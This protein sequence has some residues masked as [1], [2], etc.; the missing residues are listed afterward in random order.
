MRRHSMAS[1]GASRRVTTPTRPRRRARRSR[2]RARAR[3]GARDGANVA[4]DGDAR[5]MMPRRTFALSCASASAL[6]TRRGASASDTLRAQYA[7]AF[8]A[9][10]RNAATTTVPMTLERGGAYAVEWTLG[11]AARTLRGVVDTGSP[12]LT[13]QRRGCDASGAGA[14]WGCVE[15]EDVRFEAYDA[16]FETYGLQA[17]GRTSWYAGKRATL[18]SL[19]FE[20]LV[21]G[22]TDDVRGRDAA[23]FVG[24]VKYTN[25]ERGIRPS[26]LQQTD[27][28]SFALDFERETLTLSRDSLVDE[29]EIGVLR[30][31][32][33]RSIGAPVYH[34]ATPCDEL[35]INGERFETSKPIYVVFDSGTTGM[36]VDRQLYEDSDFHLGTYQTHMK[37][38]DTNGETKYCGSSLRTC[39]LSEDCLFVVTPID[40]PWPGCGDDFHIVFAG[41][42]VL[43][44]Q[45]ALVVDAERGLV[46]LGRLVA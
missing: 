42:S 37:F 24:L 28:A 22:V 16:T 13:S 45:G 10:R 1:R 36:L 14:G 18:G 43:R 21:F 32:D 12:F 44:N 34:Y 17:D 29:S 4:N 2:A 46:R 31:V 7:D 25:R 6:A 23:P 3:V 27:I 30:T 39:K 26:F 35:W 11:D 38:T 8:E 9:L 20:D 33:L 5:A 41:L 40:V 15:A 19:E